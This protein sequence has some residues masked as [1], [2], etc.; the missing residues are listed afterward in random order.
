MPF[1]WIACSHGLCVLLILVFASAL[2]G[3]PAPRGDSWIVAIDTGHSAENPGAYSARGVGEYTFN[4][5]I[6]S[7][8]LD[9]IKKHSRFD[10]VRIERNGEEIQLA[11]RVGLINQV[12]PDLLVS[13]H[14]DSVQPVFLKKWKWKGE[15]AYYCDRYSGFSVFY[16]E[17][18][19]KPVESLRL[20][21]LLGQ[22]LLEAGCL[23]SLHHA[24]KIK[25]ENRQIVDK[26]RGVYRFDDLAVL[27]SAT[28]PGVL[29][30]CGII[31]NRRDELLLSSYPYQRKITAAIM[32]ALIE[33]TAERR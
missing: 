6:S 29:L 16:S 4:S 18:N 9:E 13:I 21:R 33:F 25:G 14:H 22:A 28:C 23:P 26:K 20:A 30:E 3:E 31:K 32:K 15:T 19:E 27:K 12:K 17:K 1:P 8:L 24:A 11:E 7:I 5:M 2:W 10:P